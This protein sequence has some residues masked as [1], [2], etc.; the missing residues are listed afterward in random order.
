MEQFKL[1]DV[2]T[3]GSIDNQDAGAVSK[4][5]PDL[6]AK[7]PEYKNANLQYDATKE[8]WSFQGLGLTD[9]NLPLLY[10]DSTMSE[11]DIFNL[12]DEGGGPTAANPETS[13]PAPTPAPYATGTCSLELKQSKTSNTDKTGEYLFEPLI[14][15]NNGNQIGYTQPETATLDHPYALQS[16]LEE[17][18]QMT[19]NAKDR[20]RVDF[21][22]GQQVWDT[23]Q[24]D[25]KKIP[26]CE[27]T[28][29]GDVKK[30]KCKFT[31]GWAGGKS[32]D[33][34]N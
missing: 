23:T 10:P 8:D 14:I 31:C 19:P 27:K 22:L 30:Y 26:Y 2:P 24:N 3:Q 4:H 1:G 29:S 5:L 13:G 18:L 11:Q 33:G 34:T 25:N 17:L 32:S 12:F 6:D 7:S 20:G 16:K 21:V 28:P 9:D 15:D